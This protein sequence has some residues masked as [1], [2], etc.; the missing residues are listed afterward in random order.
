MQNRG[1]FDANAYNEDQAAITVNQYPANRLVLL[2][3]GNAL[4][5]G[6]GMQNG[7]LQGVYAQKSMSSWVVNDIAL[8][9]PLNGLTLV[10]HAFDA[11]GNYQTA[12]PNIATTASASDFRQYAFGFAQ[13]NNEGCWIPMGLFPSVWTADATN[14]WW[15]GSFGSVAGPIRTMKWAGFSGQDQPVATT[16]N[17]MLAIGSV[18]LDLGLTSAGVAGLKTY[19]VPSGT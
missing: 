15:P 2:P 19:A 5:E 10:S 18:N 13:F 16:P 8:P 4:R 11:Q 14:A 12:P 7:I 6:P 3:V 9:G 1:T 17:P